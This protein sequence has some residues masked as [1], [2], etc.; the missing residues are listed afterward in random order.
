MQ[1]C[2]FLKSRDILT[3]YVETAV[4][5]ARTAYLAVSES[6]VDL[7]EC[8]GVERHVTPCLKRDS[9]MRII[10]LYLYVAPEA[11]KSAATSWINCSNFLHKNDRCIQNYICTSIPEKYILDLGSTLHK[12][13]SPMCPIG[14]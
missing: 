13:R 11:T 2:R 10:S 9:G 14:S 8:D 6:F 3:V 12:A 1:N 5:Q 4:N 7:K